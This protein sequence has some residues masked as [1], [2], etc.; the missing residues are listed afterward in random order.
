P[1]ALKTTDTLRLG[2]PGTK[3]LLAE[4]GERLVCVRYRCDAEGRK[5]YKTAEIIVAEA[6]WSPPPGPD[7][8]VHDRVAFAEEELRARVKAAGGRWRPE[9]KT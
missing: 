4:F 5:R 9:T 1:W 7:D 3:R 2:E 6:D 8:P